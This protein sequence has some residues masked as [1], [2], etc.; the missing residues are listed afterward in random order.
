MNQSDRILLYRGIFRKLFQLGAEERL[1]VADGMA[2][3]E[4]ARP[5][6][7]SGGSL[8]TKISVPYCFSISS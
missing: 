3:S 6:A 4:S 2:L 1:I 5:N 7:S 8:I